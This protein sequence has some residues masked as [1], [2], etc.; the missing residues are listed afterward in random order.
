M[1]EANNSKDA[2][3]IVAILDKFLKY[4]VPAVIAAIRSMR[5]ENPTYEDIMALQI[6]KKPEDY[7]DDA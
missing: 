6:I 4:G 2:M 3:M 1:A 5:V 7:F